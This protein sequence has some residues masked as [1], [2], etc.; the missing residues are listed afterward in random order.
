MATIDEFLQE[1]RL[2]NWFEHSKEAVD[3]YHVIHSIFEAYDV[4]NK[5]MLKTWEPHI[6]SLENAAIEQIGDTEIDKI[7]LIVSSEIGDIIWEKWGNYITKWHLEEEA[8]LENEILDMVKRDV[9]WACIEKTL[10]VQGFFKT[11]LGIYKDGYLPC[12]WMGV[13]PNG[14][15]VV[16]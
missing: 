14:Q 4:W 12:A 2:I 10:N 1:V 9:S 6:F 13:Y 5:Q 8:G 16:L 15:A 11:L 7:F 3:K